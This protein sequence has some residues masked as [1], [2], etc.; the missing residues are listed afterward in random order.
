MNCW[1]QIRQYR[2]EVGEMAAKWLQNIGYSQRVFM[3]GDRSIKNRNNIDDDKRS[4]YTIFVDNLHK[5]GFKIEDK[6][7]KLCT[8]SIDYR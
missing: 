6:F 4:F 7:L 8:P 3:Y 2:K 1:V 5:F